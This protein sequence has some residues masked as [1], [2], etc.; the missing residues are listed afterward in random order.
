M[1]YNDYIYGF[2][3]LGTYHY[4]TPFRI[5]FTK[6]F[7]E[8]EVFKLILQNAIKQANNSDLHREIKE[9]DI[10]FKFVSLVFS[11]KV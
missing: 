9:D 8:G 3:V 6:E 5:S 1:K 2:S 4:N 11:G 10:N 7:E